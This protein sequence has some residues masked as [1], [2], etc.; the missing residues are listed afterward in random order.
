MRHVT[1]EDSPTGGEEEGGARFVS[2]GNPAH[3]KRE[4]R[5]RAGRACDSVTR[6]NH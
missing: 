2:F 6:P 5:K 1:N 4:S 3:R